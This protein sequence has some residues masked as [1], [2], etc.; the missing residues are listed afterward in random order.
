M[1]SLALPIDADG[2]VQEPPEAWQ[3]L[4]PE[5]RDFAPSVFIDDQGRARQLVGGEL[6]PP[7]P[8]PAEGWDIPDGGHDPKARLRDMNMQGIGRTL[9]F[10]TM[11]LMFAGLG[12]VDVQIALCRAYNDWLA[13]Y[14]ATD[15]ARLIGVAVVPQSDL[16]AALDE[17]RRTVEQLGFQSVM[18]RPNPI[19]GRTL[20]HPYWAPL[21]RLLEELDVPVSVHEGT[22]QEV[23][24]SG[25]DRFDGFTMRH[26]ASH[27]HEQQLACMELIMGGVLERHPKLR[28]VFLESGCGWLPHWLE[29]MDEHMQAWGHCIAPLPLTPTEYFQRQCF[30][31]ADPGER[32]IESVARLVGQDVLVFASDYPHPDA[33][34]ENIVGRVADREELDARL[35][36]K[37]LYRNARRCFALD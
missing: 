37:I 26:V 20:G 18:M 21:W 35:K 13:E 31:S 3:R 30:I 16:V 33:I 29:R 19:G 5:F 12:R 1:S 24:Q 36:E 9:L 11:G 8:T 7:I 6:K 25:R 14:C 10:P 23:P 15:P 4:A 27:P 2:H 17:A 22:T 28:A 34:A 32:M